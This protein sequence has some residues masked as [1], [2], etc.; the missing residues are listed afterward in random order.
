MKLYFS[1]SRFL[2][3]GEGHDRGGHMTGPRCRGPAGL[4]AGHHVGHY[5]GVT[6]YVPSSTLLD[7][8]ENVDWLRILGFLV[9]I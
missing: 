6:R 4:D 1:Y 5:A 9:H 7:F 8:L 2:W 3:H